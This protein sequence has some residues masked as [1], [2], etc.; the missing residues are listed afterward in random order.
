VV[1]RAEDTEAMTRAARARPSL[2][3]DRFIQTGWGST[4]WGVNLTQCPY[5]GAQLDVEV[6]PGGYLLLVC[7]VCDAAWETHG[8]WVGRVRGPDRHQVIAARQRAERP[9]ATMPGERLSMTY[10]RSRGADES[11]SADESR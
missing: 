10:A 4:T 11:S 5:D 8:G 1:G 3:D 2:F 6:A 9:S 7:A